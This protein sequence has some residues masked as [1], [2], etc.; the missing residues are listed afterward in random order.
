M[1]VPMRL[2]HH[3]EKPREALNHLLS[4]FDPI[5]SSYQHRGIKSF[6]PEEIAFM[7]SI[8]YNLQDFDRRVAQVDRALKRAKVTAQSR[9]H[10]SL[11]MTANEQ[12]A[13]VQHQFS[14]PGRVIL[15]EG[16]LPDKRIQIYHNH[17]PMYNGRFD[18]PVCKGYLRGLKVKE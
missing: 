12:F 7:G 5:I 8:P 13:L 18:E 14:T 6:S 9:T 11:E 15:I 1:S 4:G 2:R 16:S 17:S 3:A 10:F